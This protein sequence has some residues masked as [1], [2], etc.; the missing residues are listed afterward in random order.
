MRFLFS[1]LLLAIAGWFGYN[2]FVVAPRH[3]DESFAKAASDLAGSAFLLVDGEKRPADEAKLT[4][5]LKG[6]VTE[7]LPSLYGFP[8]L[9]RLA[10]RDAAFGA[11]GN[12]PTDIYWSYAVQSDLGGQS[13]PANDLFAAAMSKASEECIAEQAGG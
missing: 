4:V 8:V 9:S 1:I 6:K 2:Y 12:A 11:M 5:C 10:L 13:Q 3:L 7:T